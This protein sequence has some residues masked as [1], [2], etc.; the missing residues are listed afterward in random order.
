M[1]KKK[2]KGD[3]GKKEKKKRQGGRFGVVT[4]DKRKLIPPFVMLTA[5]A[6]G[7]ILMVMQ[8]GYELHGFLRNLLFIL[9]GFY[10]LGCL[11]KGALELIEQQNRPPEP[12][13][14]EV[15]EE[16]SEEQEPEEETV[17]E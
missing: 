4:K 1:A 9:F 3:T 12:E 11:M 16:G 2:D 13:E 5:G 15:K 6:A 14:E 10:I 7:S 17:E 8:G